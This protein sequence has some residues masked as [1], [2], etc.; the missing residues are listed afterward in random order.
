MELTTRAL[1]RL[2][3][4]IAQPKYPLDADLI[5]AAADADAKG[6]DIYSQIQNPASHLIYRY[7]TELTAAVLEA[8]NGKPM[9][10][11][12]VL[13]WGGGK[14]YAAYFLN[15]KEA[16]T[17]LYETSDF[18]HQALWK[19]YKL[20]VA[21]SA[22]G[23][24]PFKDKTFDAVVSFGVLE[25]VPHDYDALKEVNRVLKDTGLFFCFNLP[26]KTGYIHHVATWRGIRYHDRLYSRSEVRVLLKRAGFNIVGK[27][28]FRQLLPKNHRRYRHP[29]L[30]ER[31][32]LLATNYTPLHLTAT[33]LEFV[34]RKQYAY[35]S[36]H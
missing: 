11:L 30:I 14:G 31:L 27:P 22:D 20:D 23:A 3:L 15:K 1:R 9:R 8:H 28:W 10:E 18:P 7:L 35:T 5:K 33:S 29:Q 19:E 36:Q 34:A 17:T 16:I 2:R 32:D 4:T 24:L 13:D 12:R 25:H 26:N 6:G 21:T